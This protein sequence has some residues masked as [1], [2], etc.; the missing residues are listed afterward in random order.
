MEITE[1]Q[2]KWRW[3]D[4]LFVEENLL[5][6]SSPVDLFRISDLWVDM[7]CPRCIC[8]CVCVPTCSGAGW[9]L[10]ISYR[11]DLPNKKWASF[12]GLKTL[13]W[14]W[15]YPPDKHKSCFVV[16]A[17]AP[18][19]AIILCTRRHYEQLG[20]IIGESVGTLG[21]SLVFIWDEKAFCGNAKISI[22]TL[23]NKY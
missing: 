23:I 21:C 16:Q 9:L 11:G 3:C 18:A 20:N 19:K 7:E 13:N 6:S 14:T 17:T 4:W 8:V 1:F 15:S 5:P 10:S 12:I 2:G 22:H